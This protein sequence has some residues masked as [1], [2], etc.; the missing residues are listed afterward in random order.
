MP[1]LSTP[2]RLLKLIHPEGIPWPGTAFYNAVA[3]TSIFQRHYELLARD[4]YAYCPVGRILDIGTGPAWLLI[5]LHQLNPKLQLFGVDASAAMVVQARQN[6]KRAGLSEGVE[7]Q[8]GNV[9]S[10]PF[11]ESFFDAVI[12]TGSMHHWKSP[13]C[14]VNEIYRVLK[15]ARMAMLYDVV[16]DMPVE[17]LKKL[18]REYGWLKV[19]LFWLHAYEEPFYSY[20]EYGDLG[21]QSQFGEGRTRFVGALCCLTMEK[22]G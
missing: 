3:T 14:G 7:I 1:K 12:S 6:L 11:S 13:I 22:H 16:S 15:P 9:S 8:E 2:R 20:A 18:S 17:I 19:V 4:I 10:L 21:R 5:K